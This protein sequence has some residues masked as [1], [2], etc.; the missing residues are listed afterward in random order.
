LTRRWLGSLRN[1]R[2]GSATGLLRAVGL[3][4]TARGSDKLT[5]EQS[6]GLMLFRWNNRTIATVFA[7]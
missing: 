3:R 6:N 4:Q 2:A 7:R 1:P 5:A